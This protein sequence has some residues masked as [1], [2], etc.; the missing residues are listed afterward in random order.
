MPVR[1][2]DVARDLAPLAARQPRPSRSKLMIASLKPFTG[3]RSDGARIRKQ[4]HIQHHALA[5][6]VADLQMP[7]FI[8][9]QA[10]GVERREI[11]SV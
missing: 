7:Q 9:A 2:K 11:D 10:S 5:V 1:M 8:A 6:E 4:A 3:N